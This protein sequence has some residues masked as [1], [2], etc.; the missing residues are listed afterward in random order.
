MQDIK[1]WES[2]ISA[3]VTAHT[4]TTVTLEIIDAGT[5][6]SPAGVAGTV[7]VPPSGKMRTP[8]ALFE[9]A[10]ADLQDW[11]R[12]VGGGTA[13]TIAIQR[14]VYAALNRSPRPGWE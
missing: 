5:R 14:A 10:D 12:R 3:R 1:K 7:T 6:R 9:Y 11:C 4:L 2:R 8:R 13:R